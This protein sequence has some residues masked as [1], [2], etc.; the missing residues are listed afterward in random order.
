MTDGEWE[1]LRAVIE[2][3]RVEPLPAGLIIDSPWL[4]NWAGMS[5]LDN[6][7]SEPMWMNDS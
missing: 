3:E 1:I 6:F 5:I 2:G 7:A 4:P